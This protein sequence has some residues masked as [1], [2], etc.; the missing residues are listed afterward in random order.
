MAPSLQEPPAHQ[1]MQSTLCKQ[2]HFTHTHTHF[3]L[4]AD[5]SG[6]ALSLEELCARQKQKGGKGSGVR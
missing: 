1:G 4:K 5:G 2:Q 3:Q 6:V